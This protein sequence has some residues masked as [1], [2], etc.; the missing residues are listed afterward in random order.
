[1]SQQISLGI[2]L[3]G[4][5]QLMFLCYET[6]NLA[7]LAIGDAFLKG[8]KTTIPNLLT[9]SGKHIASTAILQDDSPYV[10]SHCSPLKNYKS[11]TITLIVA[12]P[13]E[14]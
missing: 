1:M 11:K 13:F 5:A 4:L 7:Q 14:I 3:K 8:V 9:E 2:I 12:K 10:V 6:T